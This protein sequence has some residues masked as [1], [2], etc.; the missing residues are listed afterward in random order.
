MKRIAG[1][2]EAGRGSVAGPVVA[3]AV[4]LPESFDV[5]WVS[6]SKKLSPPARQERFE[7]LVIDGAMIGVGMADVTEIDRFNILQATFLAMHRAV[8]RLPLHPATLWVDGPH[9]RPFPDIPHRCIVRGDATEPVISAASIVAK[10]WRDR[11]M[12]RLH[13]AFP[14]Y[15]WAAN[16]GYLTKAHL[17][18]IRKYGPSPH[19]RRSFHIRA[20]TPSL[21]PESS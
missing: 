16:K 3:A 17:Q 5:R 18:A 20:L 14:H 4:I 21:F 15:G 19:H 12:T 2:D 13:H 9:F 1:V 6:D 10:V 11:L 8:R 7:K